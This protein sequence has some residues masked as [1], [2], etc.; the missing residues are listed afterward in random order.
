M[1]GI[2]AALAEYD[3]E[4]IRERAMA[5]IALAKAQGKYLGR[6]PGVD[7]GKLGKVQACLAAGMSVHQ[8]VATTGVGESSVKRYRRQVEFGNP[9][10]E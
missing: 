10:T 7:A 3:R 4:S 6:R 9:D 8:T 2:F 5:G 1:L